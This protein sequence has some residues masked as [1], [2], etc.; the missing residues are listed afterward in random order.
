MPA[1]KNPPVI[2]SGTAVTEKLNGVTVESPNA[3][4]IPWIPICS[5]YSPSS[6]K[7]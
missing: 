2:G 7:P 6:E 1:A 5:S 4:P 3:P